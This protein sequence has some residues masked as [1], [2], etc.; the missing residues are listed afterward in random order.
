MKYISLFPA[1]I[2]L[3][4]LFLIAA[5]AFAQCEDCV[6]AADETCSLESCYFTE[7]QAV[8]RLFTAN[9][10]GYYTLAAE[11]QCSDP[12]DCGNCM[13]CVWLYKVGSGQVPNGYVHTAC[14]PNQTWNEA[15]ECCWLDQG[16]DYRLYVSLQHCQD[17]EDC[18]DCSNCTAKGWV[19]YPGDDFETACE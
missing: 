15:T 5:P 17:G 13:A 4:T 2:C 19:F 9:C 12:D 14:Q 8:G 16:N 10:T 7:V 1:I 6:S 3:I 18:E 11:I